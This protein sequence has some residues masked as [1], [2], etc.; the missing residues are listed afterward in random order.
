MS[1]QS[2]NDKLATAM[3]VAGNL[4]RGAFWWAGGADR[5]YINC[6][7]GTVRIN[8]VITTP[9]IHT[10]AIRQST[11]HAI[12]IEDNVVIIGNLMVHVIQSQIKIPPGSL[13]RLMEQ[14]VQLL[15]QRDVLVLL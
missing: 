15:H 7:T 11:F 10:N 9:T 6:E 1:R 5:I 2:K 14:R 3:G 13:V 4:A 12:S 8:N